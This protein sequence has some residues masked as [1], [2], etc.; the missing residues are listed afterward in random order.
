V[1]TGAPVV[2]LIV[3]MFSF[4]TNRL[5]FTLL[6][7]CVAG[8]VQLGSQRSQRSSDKPSA[9]VRAVAFLAREFRHGQNDKEK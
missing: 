1:W 4:L 7:L 6:F 2:L 8:S 9:E 5:L 3:T